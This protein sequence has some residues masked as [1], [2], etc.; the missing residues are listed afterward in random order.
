[1]RMALPAVI[2]RVAEQRDQRLAERGDGVLA[3]VPWI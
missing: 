1:M 3:D 2:A